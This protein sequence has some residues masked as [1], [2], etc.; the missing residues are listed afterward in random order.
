MISQGT[1]SIA[2]NLDGHS[3]LMNGE[4][5]TSGMQANIT[6]EITKYSHLLSLF[7]ALSQGMLVIVEIAFL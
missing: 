3:V 1:C 5:L 6:N 2:G 7:V 4:L